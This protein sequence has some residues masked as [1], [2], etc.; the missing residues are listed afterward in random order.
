MNKAFMLIREC[1]AWCGRRNKTLSPPK[2]KTNKTL[3]ISMTVFWYGE[4]LCCD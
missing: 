4:N 3:E 2:K 1:L